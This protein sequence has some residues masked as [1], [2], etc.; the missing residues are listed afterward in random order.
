[1]APTSHP[2]KMNHGFTLVEILISMLIV[3]IGFAGA[4][5]LQITSIQVVQQAI[6]LRAADAF[7]TEMSERMMGNAEMQFHNAGNPYLKVNFQAGLNQIASAPPCY[8]NHCTSNQIAVADIAEWLTALNAALPQVHAVI[9][10]DDSAWDAGNDS[11]TWDCHGSSAHPGIV[12]KLGWADKYDVQHSA[13]P[14]L[15]MPAHTL[16]E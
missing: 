11:Y 4:I 7:A 13:R 14:R 1:M 12:I 9:C 10:Q 8:T 6:Y 15:V 2:S 16:V 5:K 3:A